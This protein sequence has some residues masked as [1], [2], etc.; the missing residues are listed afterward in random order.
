MRMQC[1]PGSLIA[2][3][4]ARPRAWVRGY[5]GRYHNVYDPALIQDPAPNTVRYHYTP[6]L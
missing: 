1:V 3:H 6:G 2:T 4:A 5:C